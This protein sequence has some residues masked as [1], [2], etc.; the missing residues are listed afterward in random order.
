MLGSVTAPLGL[1]ACDALLG[2]LDPGLAGRIMP[3]ASHVV[4]TAPLRPEQVPILRNRAVSDSYFSVNYYRMTAD[5][6]LLFGGGERYFPIKTNK[7]DSIVRAPLEKIFPQMKGIAID[8]AWG[9]LVSITTS[10][11]PDIG[12]KGA[13][14]AR[15]RSC[16]R[17]RASCWPMRWRARS[18]SSM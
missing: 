1:L 10:R 6:R 11:L 7:I 3:I 13:I 9:G 18:R 2:R 16:R 4:T 14:R 8:H 17:W 12:R 5:N 15:A